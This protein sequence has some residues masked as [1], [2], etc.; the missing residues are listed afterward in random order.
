MTTICSLFSQKMTEIKNAIIT[1]IV[2]LAKNIIQML[3]E[4]LPIPQ[5]T[6]RRPALRIRNC[7]IDC[8]T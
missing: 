5:L 7:L 8:K 6:V 3:H 2:T 4:L 1:K